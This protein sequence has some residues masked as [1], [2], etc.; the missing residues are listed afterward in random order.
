MLLAFSAFPAIAEDADFTV[1]GFSYAI[2]ST[3]NL[4]VEV[5]KGPDQAVVT[6]PSTVVFNKRTFRVT[7]IGGAAFSGRGLKSIDMPSITYISD[8][9]YYDDRVGAVGAFIGCK[10]LSQVNMPS[11]TSI[12]AYAFKGCDALTSVTMPAAT[13]IGDDAF[14]G[15]EALTSVTLPVATSIGYYAFKGCDA[16]TS[17]SMPAATSI[18]GGAFSGCDALTSVS[19]PAATSIGGGAFSGCDALTSVNLPAATSIG[20]DAFSG[21]EALTSVTLPVATS[22]RQNAFSGCYALTSVTM[23]AAT[24]IDHEAFI[25]CKALTSVTLPVA[26][27]ISIY[28]FS[29]CQSLSDIY[30]G[31]DP[32]VCYYSPFDKVTYATAT[33]HV[34]AGCASKYKAAEYW[35]QFAFISEDYDPTGIKNINAEKVKVLCDNGNV[36]IT[37]LKN[38]EKIEFYSVNGQL[39]GTSVANSGAVSFKTSERIVICKIAGISIK[40]LVK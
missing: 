35:K 12:G 29:G 7:E 1:D 11:A 16:L 2:T 37:G 33:L 36:N 3:T 20:D 28:A 13:S 17:V 18:G 40:V 8:G 24:S 19:M 27:S 30:V 23:P 38:G 31:S 25:N 4:T 15:C 21:C 39:L 34:P 10:N 6:V 22:I 14:S 5:V 26:T 32:A 9:Y